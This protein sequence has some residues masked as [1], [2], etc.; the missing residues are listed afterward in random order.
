MNVESLKRGDAWIIRRVQLQPP[1]GGN[2]VVRECESYW[3][4]R[5][6]ADD[7][8]LALKFETEAAVDDTLA[9]LR[10]LPAE[11]HPPRIQFPTRRMLSV[12]FW[13]WVTVSAW[14]V[15]YWLHV[16]SAWCSEMLRDVSSPT[17]SEIELFVR[18]LSIAGP[19][20]TYGAIRGKTVQW[21]IVGIVVA[22][23]LLFCLALVHM[24]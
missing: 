14:G 23:A 13:A 12:A 16:E 8:R 7:E 3:T 11:S 10:E 5:A 4:G 15:K 22:L 17:I 20:A 1:A 2:P 6:W 21:L 9:T 19:F 24:Y 18:I